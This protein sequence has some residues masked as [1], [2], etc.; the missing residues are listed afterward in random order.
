VAFKLSKAEIQRRDGYVED[1]EKAWSEIEQAVN[2]YNEGVANL[3]APVE[4]AVAHYNEVMGEAK[5]FAEDVASQADGEWD[6]RS[7]KWQE[8]EKGEAAAEYRDAWQ[9]IEFEE[10]ELE[11]PEELAIEDPDHAPELAELPTEANP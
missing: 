3:R 8:G 2:T 7:E 1:L 5:G 10:I 9:T 4:Q 6:E 11:W